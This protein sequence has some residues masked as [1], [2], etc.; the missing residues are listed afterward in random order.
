MRLSE[1]VAANLPIHPI[2][3]QKDKN[4][5]FNS[6]IKKLN[7]LHFFLLKDPSVIL[8]VFVF[9]DPYLGQG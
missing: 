8:I 4:F 3:S 6:V 1:H 2:F 9:A 7:N 5:R